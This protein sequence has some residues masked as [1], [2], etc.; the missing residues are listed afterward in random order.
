M[1]IK[2]FL[3]PK[4]QHSNPQKRKQALLKLENKHSDYED[5]L[6]QLAL[7]PNTEIAQ[8]AISR[9]QNLQTLG[10]LLNQERNENRQQDFIKR[11]TDILC[12]NENKSPSEAEKLRF[13]DS[14]HQQE[15]LV[16]ISNRAL[17]QTLQLAA[18]KKIHSEDDLINVACQSSS[19][20]IRLAAT[21]KVYSPDKLLIL[22]KQLRGR[23]KASYRLVKDRLTLENEKRA[24]QKENI[25][26]REAL[27]SA[28]ESLASKSYFPQYPQKFALLKK[29]WSEIEVQYRSSELEQRFQQASL[30]CQALVEEKRAEEHQ[31]QERLAAAEE[32]ITTC[33]TLESEIEDFNQ[34]IQSEQI[35]I[36]AISALIKTQQIRWKAAEELTKAS[37][38]V[39]QRYHNATSY[40]KLAI[41]AYQQYKS[42]EEQLKQLLSGEQ[43]LAQLNEL[44]TLLQNIAWPQARYKPELLDRAAEALGNE[45]KTLEANKRGSQ[46]NLKAI[47]TKLEQLNAA[48]EAG[49]LK[50]ANH[51][52]RDIRQAEKDGA[53]NQRT[54][55]RFKLLGGQLKE[56]NDWQGFSSS[57][58]KEELC[59]KMEALISKPCAPEDKAN[60]IKLLQ[61]QWKQSGASSNQALWQRFKSASDTAYEPCKAYF[62]QQAEVRQKNLLERESICQ[63]LD[64]FITNNDWQSANWPAAQ[65]ILRSAKQQWKQ[66]SPV[67]R[68]KGNA[69][70]KQ[71]NN[72]LDRLN[73]LIRD[74][75]AKN[76]GKKESLIAAAEKLL[77]LSDETEAIEQAKQLQASWKTIG[78]TPRKKDEQLW[79]TFRQHCDALFERRDQSR[80]QVQEDRNQQLDQAKKLCEQLENAARL[81]NIQ[82]LETPDLAAQI[83]KKLKALTNLPKGQEEVLRKRYNKAAKNFSTLMEQAQLVHKQT[84]LEHLRTLV[85]WLN[86]LSNQAEQLNTDQLEEKW[87]ALAT[88]IPSSWLVP[89]ANRYQA[90][91]NNEAVAPQTE[92]ENTTKHKAL[93]CIRMEILAGLESPKE[94]ETER[95]AYQVSRLSEGMK[96]SKDSSSNAGKSTKNSSEAAVEIELEWLNLLEPVQ[97]AKDENEQTKLERRFELARSAFWSHNTNET[98][99][100]HQQ[101]LESSL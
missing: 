73:Q 71:F 62:S 38:D 57:H 63:Q 76:V 4:W 11:A 99:T 86:T 75:Q 53:L 12:A 35:D 51:L 41:Q 29:Q 66:F 7:D 1:I 8:L 14:C 59:E 31:Q 101:E 50:T 9:M 94:A 87:Q 23:D 84:Q 60:Q 16:H 49:S 6:K 45:K 15:L 88:D 3:T 20:T 58:K 97:T 32:L 10:E 43:S 2:R 90:I 96:S 65:E 92:Q 25:Q 55:Q 27:L 34:N 21:E 74:E 83:N 61:E 28:I 89:F 17:D 54:L 67:D 95:M 18:L 44:K 79:K 72:L 39:A 78:I 22:S 91:I 69:A 100:T 48:I 36:P 47:Q 70:Q 40:F 93:L 37:A 30:L 33:E 56:L 80:R 85:E 24:K 82:I 52:H 98:K 5:I 81:S 26:I 19:P 13:V 42:H 46:Q 68:S 64:H 77:E